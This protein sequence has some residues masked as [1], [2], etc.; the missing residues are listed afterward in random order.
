MM[1]GGIK[2]GKEATF[3]KFDFCIIFSPADK[4]SKK[5]HLVVQNREFRRK[6]NIKNGI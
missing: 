5:A 4:E 1:S 3:D 6:N 2:W